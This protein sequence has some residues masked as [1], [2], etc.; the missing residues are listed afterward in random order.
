MEQDRDLIMNELEA[1][2]CAQIE[3][4]EQQLQHKVEGLCSIRRSET[5]HTVC[6]KPALQQQQMLEV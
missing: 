1:D 5:G 3:R 4:I 2:Y 6:W